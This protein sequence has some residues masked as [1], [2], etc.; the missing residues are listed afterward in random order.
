MPEML[1]CYDYVNGITNKEDVM[2]LEVE[3]NLFAI[4]TIT[5]PKL[6]ILLAHVTSLEFNIKDFIFDFSH[7]LG[8]IF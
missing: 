4:R 5:L 2:L 3:P 6:E 8:K 1:L 7:I